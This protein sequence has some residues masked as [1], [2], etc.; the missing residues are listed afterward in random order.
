MSSYFDR[1]AGFYETTAAN[2]SDLELPENRSFLLSFCVF[3]IKKG[4]AYLS[5]YL[6]I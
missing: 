3:S 1:N 4:V 5:H 6:V 2:E